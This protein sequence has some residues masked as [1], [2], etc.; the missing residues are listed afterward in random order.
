[1]IDETVFTL[2]DSI[3]DAEVFADVPPDDKPY[4]Q[5]VYDIISSSDNIALDQSGVTD[6]VS[7]V[8]VDVRAQSRAEAVS[9]S[10]E[11]NA[12]LSGYRGVGAF[13]E[14]NL[15]KRVDRRTIIDKKTGIYRI[16][17][18]YIVYH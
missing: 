11:L 16:I 13:E 4:P 10:D 18:D 2:L 3:T 17:H 1:M 5:I 7:R 12:T 9:L 15:I 6:S 8:Q 14:I